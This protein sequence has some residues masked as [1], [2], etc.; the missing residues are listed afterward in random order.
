LGRHSVPD[1]EESSDDQS[2]DAGAQEYPSVPPAAGGAP[3]Y[4]GDPHG[5]YDEPEY[6]Q[7]QYEQPQY[8]QP[9]YDEPEYEAGYGAREYADADYPADDRYEADDFEDYWASKTGETRPRD[10]NAFPEPLAG[11]EDPEERTSVIPAVGRPASRPPSSKHGG[12]WE[13]GDWTGSHRA[14]QTGRRGVSKGVIAALVTV[15]VVVGAFI[16][17]RFIGD[18]LSS[19][20]QIAAARC[21]SGEVAVAV[22]ADPS[23]ADDIRGLAD[24]Y[25]KSAAPIGD[26]CVKVGVTAANANQVIDGY[27]GQWPG[28]L[29]E[30]P[31]LWI[32]GSSISAAR[33]ESVAGKDRVSAT[34][35]LVTSPVL[36]AVRPE[37]KTALGQQN[38]S[39]L[40]GLQSNP[41][42]LD[43]LRLNGWG[44]LRLALP[45]EE[46]GDAA[47]VAAEAVAAASAP[48]GSPATA[49]A[50]AISQLFAGQPKL[51]DGKLSTAF[52]ALLN[53]G[54]PAAS[55]VHAVVTTEQELYQR[56]TSTDGAKDKLAGWLPGGP[57]ALADYP[58]VQLSGD[59]LSKE[60]ITAAS[61]FDRYLRKPEALT[62]LVAAGFRAQADGAKPPS[63][64]VV[65]FGSLAQPLAIGDDGVRVTLANA[66]SSPTQSQTV[67]ILLDQS[68]NATENG[69]S[70]V[71]NVAAAITDRLKAIPPTSAVGL[72]TFDG[73]AGRSEIPT[74]PLT[75][76]VD[77]KPRSAALA[78]NLNGQ[79]ASGGGAVSFTTLRLLYTDA[80]ANF[81]E[82]QENSVLVITQGPHT[83]Q[84]LDGPG[85][86]AFVKQTFSPAKPVAINVIDFGGDPDRATWE[87]VAQSTGGNYQNVASSAGP[88]LTAAV[89]TGIS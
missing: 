30:R 55:E 18:S 14:I 29:G 17:W 88:E 2:Y 11:F 89:T 51:A 85:L 6:E 77:G 84:S 13:G 57:A 56:G 81:R 23:I 61:E 45:L 8:G 48:A 20:S 31:A 78:D 59:G 75:D 36:L 27:T 65:D 38:W 71:A 35:S 7:P 1:P 37:L 60:Q 40:P 44:P 33:L 67:T 42:A 39:A 64:D 70:R 52:D 83:D 12:E 66:V 9:R 76:Q 21:V 5:G 58:A 53:N 86:E 3:R 80:V 19:R 4:Q 73:V 47:Y 22:I 26:K 49:G 69:K 25:A 54:T 10:P 62:K 63:S 79:V 74:G 32:P 15:V 24:E 50:G 34:R 28:D 41:T 82:G 43:G 87:A 68:M 46:N 16:L 72:W